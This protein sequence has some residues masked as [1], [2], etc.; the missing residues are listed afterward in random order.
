M[1]AERQTREAG[2]RLMESEQQLS[3]LKLSLSHKMDTVE[4]VA[5][6]LRPGGFGASIDLNNV[7]F[8]IPVRPSRRKYLRLFGGANCKSF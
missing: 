6:L 4:D 7:Y 3:D 2:Q 5:S 8:H 1:E